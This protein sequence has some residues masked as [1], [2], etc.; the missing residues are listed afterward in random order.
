MGSGGSVW[1][2]AEGAGP[3]LVATG[4]FAGARRTIAGGR[5]VVRGKGVTS[6]AQTHDSPCL[7]YWTPPRRRLG[8]FSPHV[9]DLPGTME[10]RRASLTRIAG[11]D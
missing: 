7:Q 9:N 5:A 2:R 8:D 10:P 1:E 11:Q 3:G 4:R 6:F